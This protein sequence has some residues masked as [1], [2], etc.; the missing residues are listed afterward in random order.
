MDAQLRKAED[1]AAEGRRRVQGLD[2]RLRE[3]RG[4]LQRLDSDRARVKREMDLERRRLDEALAKELQALAGLQARLQTVGTLDVARRT[5]TKDLEL[6][7]RS[8]AE[9]LACER[10]RAA[11][12]QARLN[13]AGRAAGAAAA[14]EGTLR[15]EFEKELPEALAEERKRARASEMALAACR[16]ELRAISEELAEA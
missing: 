10:R 3:R 9:R 5:G 14:R 1:K 15:R 11:G 7:L 2:L 13:E 8:T 6:E 12:L 4:E 16:Q